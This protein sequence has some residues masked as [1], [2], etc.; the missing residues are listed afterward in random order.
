MSKIKKQI[1][2]TLCIIILIMQYMP[3]IF[4]VQLTKEDTIAEFQ[5][6]IIHE[7]GEEASG[8]LTDEQKFLYDENQYGYTIGSTPILKITEKN[9][10][11]EDTLYCLDAKKSFPATIGDEGLLY[12]NCGDFT[13][14]ENQEVK[15]L[16][17]SASYGDSEWEENY[18]ALKWLFNNFY[19]EKQTPEQKDDFLSKAFENST[20]E[21]D[22][23]KAY[24][25]D[26]DIDIVQQY[27]IWYFTNR[28]S[29]E[30]NVTT[31]PAVTLSGFDEQGS[32]FDGLSY[33]DVTGSQLRQEMANYLYRYLIN[34]ALDRKEIDVIYPSIATKDLKVNIEDEYFV[35]GPY[36][37]NSGNVNS[38]EYSIKL[39]DQSNNE[40]SQN[41]YNILIEGESNFTNKKID[42]IFDTN[43]YIYLPKSDNKITKIN[44]SLSYSKYESFATLWKNK[45]VNGEGVE[46]YQPTVLLT[47]DKKQEND[48]IEVEVPEL[49][50]IT[51]QK[52]W[53]DNEN[54][55]GLRTDYE[56]TLTGKIEDRVV[57]ED[58][59]ILKSDT[60]SYTWKDLLKFSEGQEIIYTV[61]ETKVPEGY[62][63]NVNGY[64]I[65]NTHVPEKTSI[66]I[67]KIWSDSNNQDGKRA[68][69]EV[70]LTGKV[71][72]EIVYENSQ[73]LQSS[74]IEYTWTN[75]DKYK[76][77]Q[78]IIYT[79]D[80]TKVPEGY[81]KNVNGYTITNTY[82]PEKT[83]V[84]I[85]KIWNDS[86][87]QDGKR[88]NY[89]VTLTGKVDGEIVYE[90]SQILQSN[91][92]E[93]TWTNLDKYKNGQEIIYTVD[94]TKVPEG[95]TKNVN[96]YT[97]TNTYVP[98]K[99]SITMNKI[100]EDNNNQDGKRASYEVTLTGTA[101]GEVVY[102]DTKEFNA[103]QIT[104]TWTDL[105]KHKN[106]QEIIYTIDETKVPEGYTKNINGYTITN[107][108][109]PEKTSV[110]INKIWNDNE[111]QDKL[112]AKYEV[113]LTGRA[114]G[115]TVYTDTKEFNA[116][117]LA[118]T[119]SD[120]D[121]YK[122]GQ[123][124]I[125][126]IDETKVPEGYTKEVQDYTIINT[127]VPEKAT[128]TISK[129][130]KD[131]ENQ[132]GKR[133]PYEVTL[134]GTVDGEIVYTDTKELSPD[135]TTYTWR[136]LEKYRNNKE[137]IYTIDETKVP[138]GYTKEINGYTII[139]TYIPEETSIT[140]NKIWNDN[141]NQ[142]G[143]RTSYEVTL[144]GIVDG[145]VVYTN[146]K[147]LEADQTTYT[148]NYLDKYKDGKEVIYKVDET[149]VP[150]GYTKNVDGYTITNTYIPEKIDITINKI[151]KDNE[152]QD[153]KRAPY[154]VTLTGTLDGEVVYADT[155]EFN[156]DQITY[157][158]TNLDKY[159]D[160]QEI[161]YTIDETEVPEG[162]TKEIQDYTIINTHVPEKT[163]VT[164]NKIWNDSEN[165]DELRA[166]YEVTL[167]GTLDG[168]VVYTDTKEFNSDQITYTWDNL[169][170]YKNGQEI[171][172]T[173]DETKVPDEYTKEV[174]G[175]TITNTHILREFDLNLKKF[176]TKVNNITL[177]ESREPNVDTSPLKNET[178][179]DANYSKIS[180][181][182]E[183]EIG[184]IVTYTI[185]VYNEGEK[186][187]YAEKITDYI[188]EGLGYLE[189]YK[190]NVENGWKLEEG[191]NIVKL[192]TLR[193]GT[194]NLTIEDFDGIDDLSDVNVIIGNAKISSSKLSSTN[195]DN[196]IKEFDRKTGEKLEYK[197][198]EIAC[199]VVSDELTCDN[200][201]NIAEIV[202]DKDKNGKDVEDIDSIPDTVN[203]EDYPNTE[204]REDDTFQ[205]D[206]DYEDLVVKHKDFD[207]SLQKFITNI[208]D[209]KIVDREPK[210]EINENGKIE[211][212]SQKDPLEVC[213]NDLITYT[214]RVYN[215]GELSGY[216]KEISDNLPEG[217][218]FVIDSE[219]NK[220]YGWKLYDENGEETEDLSKA[221]IV[222]TNYLSK[223][224]SEGREED[225]LL[226]GFNQ[227]TK[228]VDY[229]DLQIVFKVVEDSIDKNTRIIQNIAEITDDEDKDGDD[230]EDI[231]SIPNNGEETEDDIDY[232]EIYVKYFDLKLQKDLVKIIIEENG[233]VKE[234]DVSSESN[235]PSVQVHSSLIEKTIVKFVYKIT[236]TNEGEIA[237]YA[238]EI[239]DY[240]P[241]GLKFVEQDNEDWKKIDENTIITNK[242]SEN[243]L[244]PGESADVEV[245]LE[246]ENS[247]NNFGVKINVAEI[248]KDKN[249]SDTPDIDSTP[250]N[251]IEG[252]DDIDEAPVK[253]E[254]IIDKTEEPQTPK[255]PTPVVA[256]AQST[257]KTGDIIPI[258][259]I[260][261]IILVIILNI[262]YSIYLNK[263]KNK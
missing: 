188:P 167:T 249:D 9:S 186:P 183:V 86:N 235:I 4:A 199:I 222:K 139:N 251:K 16:H 71:D 14:I 104:Y 93:Y 17:L 150:E 114:N 125:Y 60:L 78:E 5:S 34:S 56:V 48:N 228:E 85:N 164:I 54:Q 24:L 227:A 121:K 83:S 215:E 247:E 218:E 96:G 27:A 118:Y 40:I 69:Y 119:W 140:I 35:I 141:E 258:I 158:W 143:K 178:S 31:L 103:G 92:T 189:G 18:E 204:K 259:A 170:K 223:E 45:T 184:D 159:K 10:P 163:S 226:E 156:P 33:L 112:R 253:L 126:T 196:L 28:D 198:L 111:N 127:H 180:N 208:N 81:T 97:I 145:K 41:N 137:I 161:V 152:N 193:K 113:T 66:T 187:G 32:S 261:V 120:L 70:T 134:T 224:V 191:D 68:S 29:A 7:G 102:T 8:T 200:F 179:T 201:K 243:K 21:L 173:V 157:A 255:T 72:G 43:Y 37:I 241:K 155:K 58:S 50:D 100:W 195:S 252:E 219:I 13:N 53:D 135:Q 245:I 49:I 89:E 171:V 230:I 257:P 95:Y 44:L 63:K 116:D 220:K 250:D 20:Y 117:Q 6:L 115:Q 67:N 169:D 131:N 213:N 144:T 2:S 74:E 42:E 11:Y 94:E 212:I 160:G 232:E 99:T 176:I 236:I 80:E 64:A 108:H 205:D 197:D 225:C 75:L 128:I 211:F 142:A 47:R 260:S 203:P 122:D 98:E 25:T 202:V 138:E 110:T 248:S 65:T 51:V 217:L 172:Y 124:I 123:E 168:E 3:S 91:E 107:T 229:I 90:N 177:E 79:V 238:E 61:D 132:D 84:T 216:A 182:V 59:Q 149:K 256:E 221:K 166:P 233:E 162:Y 254:T 136:D 23:V 57:F 26:D 77:G 194:K 82:V 147:T 1:L 101:D 151:W 239:K 55:D 19:L 181:P 234:I 262:G 209:E 240:I 148:W 214:I 237:G 190:V 30:Y 185:R 73:I 62:I 22:V 106:G 175:Y 210:V 154:K 263:K 231:D 129:V 46:V 130:W 38:S 109:I 88:T 174:N 244:E 146:T 153:G 165:Q 246:W 207:L 105:E 12:E 133:A 192:D 76:N 242:L 87:N 39:L 15:S 36:K 206:N 52:K